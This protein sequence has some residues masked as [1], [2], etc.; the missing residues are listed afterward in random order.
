MERL[1][2]DATPS[3]VDLG[4]ESF[5]L[6]RLVEHRI[7]KRALELSCQRARAGHQQDARVG[8][9]AAQSEDE[10]ESSAVRKS[11]VQDDERGRPA[12]LRDQPLGGADARRDND[13]PTLLFEDL[14]KES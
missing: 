11:L 13:L 12:Q 14:S 10:R 9:S 7:D 2:D 1:A 5:Q 8:E 6:D 4:E 3:H